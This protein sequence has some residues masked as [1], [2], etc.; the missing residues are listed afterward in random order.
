MGF[1]SSQGKRVHGAK[2]LLIGMQSNGCTWSGVA[3]DMKD[4]GGY[5][6]KSWGSREQ[7]KSCRVVIWKQMALKDPFALLGAAKWDKLSSWGLSQLQHYEAA[8]NV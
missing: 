8:V 2:P 6:L 4:A 7:R 1:S 5:C 3:A